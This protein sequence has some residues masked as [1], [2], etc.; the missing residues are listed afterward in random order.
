MP[1]CT[2]GTTRSFTL[3]PLLASPEGAHQAA[4]LSEHPSHPY[5]S[6]LAS[7]GV[8]SRPGDGDSGHTP[9]PPSSTG[10]A[11][12]PTRAQV[13]QQS[14]R[15]SSNRLAT[16][17][18]L[19]RHRGYSSR[20]ARFLARSNRPSTALNYQ[21]KWQQYGRWCE[22]EGHTVSSP[23][24]Q[25]FAAFLVFLRQECNL[26]TS[27]VKGYK[28]MLNSVFSLTGFD[29]SQDQVLRIIIKACSSQINGPRVSQTPSWNVDVVLRSLTRPPL[30]P[31]HQSSLRN[32][33]KKT[34]FLVALA[35]ANCVGE[36]QALSFS[37]T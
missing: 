1:F 23:S 3:P 16:I 2:T 33:T 29:L 31:L 37:V 10:P 30:E 34:L 36:L 27:A 17:K 9:A 4:V 19:L 15:A 26:S 11:S 24:S 18:R 12:P 13:S 20:V 14:P 6:F 22:R 35:S 21:Y 5:C 25:R 8:V 28:A 32:V 7:E